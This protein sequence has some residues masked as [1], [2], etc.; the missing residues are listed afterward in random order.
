M[1]RSADTKPARF[2]EAA[3]RCGH[4]RLH[5]DCFDVMPTMERPALVL[6]DPPYGITRQPWDVPVKWSLWWAI[7]RAWKCPTL[8]FASPPFDKDMAATN[9]DHYRYDW[10]WEKP[11]ATGHLNSALRPM[12]AHESVL[13]FYEKSPTYNPQ[14][15]TGHKPVNAVYTRRTS[16][17]YGDASNTQSA[18]G[19]TDRFPRT[20]LQFAHI[21]PA[22]KRHPNE[23]PQELLRY[24]IRTYSNPG[25]LV[26]DP[27]AGSRSTGEAAVA[28][29]R[30]A[31]TVEMRGA[32]HG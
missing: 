20:V 22:Q 31:I 1:T 6:T 30:R 16:G 27:F 8:V 21:S 10:I 18:R 11:L 3:R 32:S 4:E 29:G 9:R 28:E 26:L 15:T 12:Q 17:V 19:Q 7:V 5:A 2:A 23:K 25:D 13:V 14:K 24:L